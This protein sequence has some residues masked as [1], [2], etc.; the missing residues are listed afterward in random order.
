VKEIQDISTVRTLAIPDEVR[1]PY[2]TYGSVMDANNQEDATE[3]DLIPVTDGIV[4]F[5]YL[6]EFSGERSA[7]YSS[8]LNNDGGWYIDVSNA[9]GEDGRPFLDRFDNTVTN[10]LVELNIN[11][12]PLGKWR[13]V[14]YFANTDPTETI[15]LNYP[16]IAEGIEDSFILQKIE[17]NSLLNNLLERTAK[18]INAAERDCQSTGWCSWRWYNYDTLSW[19]TC[20]YDELSDSDKA[21]YASRKCSGVGGEMPNPEKCSGDVSVGGFACRSSTECVECLDGGLWSQ[22]T[23]SSSNCAGKPCGTGGGSGGGTAQCYKVNY[24]TGADFY[25]CGISKVTYSG[26][27]T[28]PNGGGGQ[29][30]YTH[31]SD[32]QSRANILNGGSGGS[33]D[34]GE[35]GCETAKG[36]N[37]ENCP[38]DCYDSLS[39]KG[40]SEGYVCATGKTC[41]DTGGC[42]TSGTPATAQCFKLYYNIGTGLHFCGS[43]RVTYSGGSN[44]PEGAGGENYFSTMEGCNQKREELDG[45][46]KTTISPGSQCYWNQA[47]C[48]CAKASTINANEYCPEFNDCT[49]YG[50]ETEGRICNV[51]GARCLNEVCGGEAEEITSISPGD[52]CD[53]PPCDCPMLSYD[54]EI[55]GDYCPETY[56]CSYAQSNMTPDEIDGLICSPSG[57]T[58]A[59]GTC[60]GAS[61]QVKGVSD[62]KLISFINA[63]EITEFVIDG[64]LGLLSELTPGN[65]IFE[66]E[67]KSYRFE[68]GEG[69]EIEF[70]YIDENDNSIYDEDVD[71]LVSTLSSKIVVQTRRRE[72]NYSLIQGINFF[73]LPYLVSDPANRTAGG[74]LQSL[75]EEYNDSIYSISKFDGGKWKMVGQNVELYGNDDF[76]LLPGEGYIIKAKNDVDIQILGRPIKFESEDDNAPI[77]FSE[78]WNLIGL[79]GTKVKSY[80]AK[81]LIEDVNADEFTAD[82]VTKWAK[83]TQAYEGFQMTDGEEYGF[84]YPLNKLESYFVRIREG[85]GNWQP[86]LGGNN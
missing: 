9:V 29:N 38:E 3:K 81:S 86:S 7:M 26:G 59:N 18:G 62:K 84:D 69:A 54:I 43:S 13:K 20:T 49:N 77:Y 48:T 11:A 42:V 58:C 32:C 25:S 34:C 45:S 55:E 23:V 28:C 41:N 57:T 21:I 35:N 53:S 82:N 14:E 73:S 71:I 80:T 74:L 33:Y 44:C 76:Q 39:C 10:I 65:Y 30:Y 40:K 52:S 75:N 70:I 67:G 6:D 64:S 2:P 5:N 78:G 66:Y 31:L 36:E 60:S 47:P 24:N 37:F 8:S 61:A 17:S 12:G 72:Y 85:Q 79:Y 16:G 51:S 1:S 27:S 68:I 56:N 63:E 4:Y 46:D 50:Q 22:E 83:K 15:V 19:V